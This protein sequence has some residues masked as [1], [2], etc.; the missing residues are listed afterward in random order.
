MTDLVS[1][2]IY[3]K[4]KYIEFLKNSKFD[5]PG[6][7]NYENGEKFA[8]YTLFK[9]PFFPN[10]KVSYYDVSKKNF[11]IN[12][13]KPFDINSKKFIKDK[14]SITKWIKNINEDFINN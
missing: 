1:V 2:L 3:N 14:I 12:R 9:R 10:T 11:P 5:F 4:K 13:F 7:L 6:K 8:Y